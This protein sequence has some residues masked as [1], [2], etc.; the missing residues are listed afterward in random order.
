MNGS[1]ISAWRARENAL[2][3]LRRLAW[4]VT[5]LHESPR[6]SFI[7]TALRRGRVSSAELPQRRDEEPAVAWLERVEAA[8]CRNAY[9]PTDSAP[10]LV[11]LRL[12]DDFAELVPSADPIPKET[13]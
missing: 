9:D 1:P 8:L 6:G 13:A 12:S 11:V 2:G 5:R 4:T 10:P 3:S 7:V